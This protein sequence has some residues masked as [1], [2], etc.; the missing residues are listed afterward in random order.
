ML[1]FSQTDE[2]EGVLRFKVER[3]FERL[4]CIGKTADYRVEVA[5]R[6]PGVRRLG[7]GLN[8]IL[9]NLLG[10]LQIVAR[11]F[12]L[13]QEYRRSKTRWD[14]RKRLVQIPIGRAFCR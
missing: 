12:H 4:Q 5:E 11:H 8:R 7:R 6:D 1:S 14:L 13:C 9:Q 10:P 2:G 3:G